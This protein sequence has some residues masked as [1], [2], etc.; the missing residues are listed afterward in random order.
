M[1]RL[2]AS[3]YSVP[4]ACRVLMFLPKMRSPGNTNFKAK[5]GV[6]MPLLGPGEGLPNDLASLPACTG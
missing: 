5:P 3:L 4:Q 2:K 1:G 6:S